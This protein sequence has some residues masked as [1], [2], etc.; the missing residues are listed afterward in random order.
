MGKYL[1]FRIV[2]EG[3]QTSQISHLLSL[4]NDTPELDQ[5]PPNDAPLPGADVALYT[6]GALAFGCV[7]F[8]AA[9]IATGP[10]GGPQMVEMARKAPAKQPQVDRVVAMGED[11]LPG[12]STWLA[13]SGTINP[14]GLDT[15]PVGTIT[16]KPVYLGPKP[17]TSKVAGLPEPLPVMEHQRTG[18]LRSNITHS[19]G[20]HAARLRAPNGTP[21]PAKLFVRLAQRAPDLMGRL[22][23]SSSQGELIAG[24]FTTRESVASFCRSVVLRLTLGCEPADWPNSDG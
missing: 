21:I 1:D 12:H 23:A 24:P 9:S 19:T 16:T 3:A 17:T 7:A 14:E 8:M 6:W 15:N 18:E 2:E 4:K 13:D 10:D 22:K 11:G 20:K 5:N